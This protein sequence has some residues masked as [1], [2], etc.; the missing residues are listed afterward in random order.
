MSL[1]EPPNLPAQ[2][3]V[4]QHG[5]QHCHHETHHGGGTGVFSDQPAAGRAQHETARV[6]ARR[7]RRKAAERRE[8]N[9]KDVGIALPSVGAETHH[10]QQRDC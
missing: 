4:E 9:R 7:E 6:V 3:A 2:E 8:V 5:R 1:R 10:A